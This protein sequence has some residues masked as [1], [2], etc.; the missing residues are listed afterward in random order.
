[1]DTATSKLLEL[2]ENEIITGNQ[3]ISGGATTLVDDDLK[4][5]KNHLNKLV[6]EWQEIEETT[7]RA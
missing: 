1:M 7:A 2:N 6:D 3:I 4:E 5:A